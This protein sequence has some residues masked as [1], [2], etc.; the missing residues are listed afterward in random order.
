[1]PTVNLRPETYRALERAAEKSGKELD[2]AAEI[3]IAQFLALDEIS[4]AEY[5]RAWAQIRRDI[6]AGLPEGLTPADVE[7]DIFA[8]TKEAWAERRSARSH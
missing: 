3:A 2:D 4:D 7:A 1:M 6:T 5:A 8:A